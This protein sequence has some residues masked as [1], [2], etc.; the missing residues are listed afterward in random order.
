MTERAAYGPNPTLSPTAITSLATSTQDPNL[1]L[2]IV[3]CKLVESIEARNR[4]V[5]K[6]NASKS[7]CRA[8]PDYIEEVSN[9]KVEVNLPDLNTYMGTLSHSHTTQA[10]L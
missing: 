6:L 1:N 9:D 8:D 10:N 2:N 5:K 7:I 3:F 4:M